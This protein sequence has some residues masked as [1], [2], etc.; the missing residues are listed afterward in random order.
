MTALFNRRGNCVF[1]ILFKCV[2]ISTLSQAQNSF[3][4]FCKNVLIKF[5]RVCNNINGFA[6]NNSIYKGVERMP[7]FFDSPK[8]VQKLGLQNAR[9]NPT[10]NLFMNDGKKW[11]P[12]KLGNKSANTRPTFFR[13][14]DHGWPPL[15]EE[16][17]TALVS[18]G[19]HN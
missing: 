17:L 11:S 15:H 12:A 7:T 6:R 5:L 8:I 9:P 19:T 10:N 16:K 14:E 3:C 13:P 4:S 1:I 18:L 2:C